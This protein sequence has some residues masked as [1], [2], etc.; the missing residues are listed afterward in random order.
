[1]LTPS[2]VL[3]YLAGG[4]WI[5]GA[6]WMATIAVAVEATRRMAQR[7]TRGAD[8]TQDGRPRTVENLIVAV[9]ALLIAGI[10]FAI[11][12]ESVSTTAHGWAECTIPQGG[13]VEVCTGSVVWQRWPWAL[14]LAV[15]LSIV[16]F[17]YIDLWLIRRGQELTWLRFVPRLAVV[18]TIFL[19][20]ISASTWGDRVAHALLLF[21]YAVLAHVLRHAIETKRNGERASRVDIWQWTLAPRVAYRTWRIMRL[22]KLSWE[23]AT[24]ANNQRALT[25]FWLIE[26]YRAEFKRPEKRA[27]RV[28]AGVRAARTRGWSYVPPELQARF[29]MRDFDALGKVARDIAARVAVVPVEAGNAVA[30][31]SNTPVAGS[32]AEQVSGPAPA[33]SGGSNVGGPGGTLVLLERVSAEDWRAAAATL[34]ATG[35]H[36]AQKV[37]TATRVAAAVAA[38]LEA[39]GREPSNV[40][41]GEA[42]GLSHT[43]AGQYRKLLRGHLPRAGEERE[44]VGDS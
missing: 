25:R 35:G 41:L 33:V 34:A 2:E 20:V 36:S 31:G 22:E 43:A 13:T 11:S 12:F 6:A 42:V 16:A 7:R 4:P 37:A 29:K 40:D 24:A 10:A 38:V 26:H 9:A 19:N 17:D 23:A 27:A 39:E 18:G 8:D 44:A 15:D 32:V 21:N 14:P 28:A 1:M 3:S 5:V 30:A